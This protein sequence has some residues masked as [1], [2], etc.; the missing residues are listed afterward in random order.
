MNLFNFSANFMNSL[1]HG[2]YHRFF[3]NLI[4]AL[5]ITS[6]LRAQSTAWDFQY[7]IHQNQG[8]QSWNDGLT[9][10]AGWLD[11]QDF[12]HQVGTNPPGHLGED[13]NYYDGYGYPNEGKLVFAVANG[14]AVAVGISNGLAGYVIL[15]HSLP[16]GGYVLSVYGHLHNLDYRPTQGQH[17]NKGDPIG[18]LASQAEMASFT[19]AG[20]PYPAHLHF[21]IRGTQA[22]TGLTDTNPNDGYDTTPLGYFDPTDVYNFYIPGSQSSDWNS[23]L[24]FVEQRIPLPADYA[25]L[26]ASYVAQGIFSTNDPR[27]KDTRGEFAAILVTAMRD[28][29]NF[30]LPAP[31]YSHRFSDLAGHPFEDEVAI[32]LAMG[33]ISSSN[34]NFRVNDP[35][36][37]AEALA[38]THSCLEYFNGPSLSGGTS[39][40]IYDV[41]YQRPH[42]FYNTLQKCIAQG[43][44]A[45]L[46][47]QMMSNYSYQSLGVSAMLIPDAPI[48]RGDSVKLFDNLI[49]AANPAD[50]T[51]PT[52]AI[53]SPSSNGTTVTNAT[54]S[55]GGTASDNVGVS[56]VYVSLN[57][58]GYSS[59]SGTTSW[60]TSR[61]LIS[62]SNTISAYS[63]DAAGN[64]STVATRTVTYSPTDTTIP[65]VAITSP[66][67]NGTTVTSA[68]LS[69][70]GTA[71]DNVGV[72]VVYVSLNG[73]SY[74]SASGTTSWST[75]R[76]L[77]SGS[78]TISAYSQDAEG[79]NSTVATRT[80]TY[81]PTDAINPT[82]AITTPSTDGTTV[83]N[84]TVSISGTA[85]DNVGVVEVFA[86]L[87]GGGYSSANGTTSWSTNRTLIVGSNT[88]SAYA[89]DAAGNLSNVVSRTLTYQP[90]GSGRN[91]ATWN[92]TTGTP[93]APAASV[94]PGAG[95]TDVTLTSLAAVS[96]TPGLNEIWI[97]NPD[98]SGFP[99]LGSTEIA[100]LD[101]FVQNGGV[102]VFFDYCV[103]GASSFIPGAAAISFTRDVSAPQS[104]VDLID[105]DAAAPAALVSGLTNA[106][107]DGGTN[108]SH[109]FMSR[110]T[111]PVG[112]VPVLVREQNSAHVAGAIY[113][114]GAGGVF[115][116]GVP[117]NFYLDS[118]TIKPV[119]TA[120]L[121]TLLT[122]AANGA[123]AA[124]LPGSLSTNANLSALALGGGAVLSP[125]FAS[126]TTSYTT[127]VSYDTGSILLTP[128][129]AQAGATVRVNGVLVPAASNAFV[130][131]N[132]GVN[133]VTTVVT[134]E[135]GTTT[136]TYTLTV[137]RSSITSAKSQLSSPLPGSTL[138]GAITNFAWVAG[139]SVTEYYLNIGSSLGGTDIYNANQGTALSRT[140]TVPTDGRTL[141]VKLWSKINGAWQT[142]TY[143]LTAWTAPPPVKAAMISPAPNAVFSSA[144]ATFTWDAGVSV[145]QYSLW[146]GSNPGGY[147]L[148]NAGLLTT[149]SRTVTLPVDGRRLYVSLWTF[150][151]GSWQSNAY[152]YTAWTT[153][154]PVKAKMLGPVP[155]GGTFSSPSVTFTWDAGVGVNQ[156]SL[157]VGNS[158]GTY[159]LQNAGLLTS[160]LT[161]TVSLPTDGRTIY[162][163]LWTFMNGAWKAN[164][165]Y[166]GTPTVSPNSGSATMLSPSPDSTLGSS[167]VTFTWNPAV[168]SNRYSL[169]VGNSPTLTSPDAYSLYN[170][171]LITNQ[172]TAT[173]TL[174]T[175]GRTLHVTLWTDVNGSWQAN[176]YTY[177]AF[178]AS[179]GT[180]RAKMLT[181]A[182]GSFLPGATV[183]FTWDAGQGATQYSLWIGGGI[184][185]ATSTN[186]EAYNIHNAGLLTNTYSRTVTL[187]TDGSPVY[188]TLWTLIN[189][190]WQSNMYNYQAFIAP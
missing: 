110:A 103:T 154:P 50:T 3:L 144:T 11:G 149:L 93:F 125:G 116:M 157:W 89:R 21:E 48:R 152:T 119:I 176:H 91:I 166:Y 83:A 28:R 25:T 137:T 106:T 158:P 174:P 86:S 101:M 22:Q 185:N 84:A 167:S 9:G 169:W 98:N 13:W 133:P 23:N 18:R 64:T 41:S 63:Q 78:N 172:T 56:V 66:S 151:N 44:T 39:R 117:A 57:G 164:N 140:V 51:V 150:I 105:L 53:T 70:S 55:I 88:I 45:G 31:N 43:L 156:Y 58:G 94:I 96:S 14:Q 73:G 124:S 187:P 122:N 121:N 33:A 181:P 143:T 136:K 69:I 87:N 173:A 108:S 130:I 19:Y 75:S 7:P 104:N 186:P 4:F 59:A 62:G 165:Y 179:G 99:G 97:F 68:T 26:M 34:T 177:T 49:A 183:T 6:S 132:V 102:L 79:N 175:D 29:G 71:S 184:N 159:D 107:F 95:K 127:T 1:T 171:G 148:H 138:T 65:T 160:T 61:T 77:I 180:A 37:R 178:T 2:S 134:A 168:G 46:A 20:Y 15:K 155:N 52:V 74:S 54:L 12:Q 36:T 162:V 85:S 163:S 182:N 190:K 112:A 188:V 111:L 141:H 170:A 90:S 82:I 128:T 126:G 113:R 161:R 38:I 80:V 120:G 147:D 145:S 146:V 92:L 114:H 32:L 81:S 35:I 8:L 42:A 129:V 30:A 16:E 118:P 115:Y 27:R 142:N 189:G 47:Q 135:N 76:T 72:S 131:L 24:G 67:A 40:V 153:P 123:V 5:S 109:G 60:S 100:N 139:V 10:N 17:V